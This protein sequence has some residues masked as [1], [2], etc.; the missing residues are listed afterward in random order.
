M[1]PE[2]SLILSTRAPIGHIGIAGVSLCTNQG[3]RGLVYRHKCSNIYHYFQ[4]LAYRTALEELGQGSTFNE[5]SSDN[6]GSF[7]TALPPLPEQRAIVAFLDRETAR[8]DALVEKKERLIELLQ[9]KRAALISHAVTRGLDPK[10]AHE[11]LGR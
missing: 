2:G 10:A 9:E 11:R 6:L 7:K 4:F 1:I 3:C 8:I 5:L